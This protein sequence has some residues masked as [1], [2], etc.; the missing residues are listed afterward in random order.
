MEQFFYFDINDKIP[1]IKVESRRYKVSFQEIPDT[2]INTKGEEST[3]F[4]NGNQEC[5]QQTE[6]RF[7][8]IGVEN[9]L[10]NLEK[11]TS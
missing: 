10:K 11:K 3:F 7:V 2:R 1:G 5:F 8:L 9:L 6:V 4:K